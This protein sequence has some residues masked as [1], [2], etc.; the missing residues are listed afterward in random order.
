MVSAASVANLGDYRLKCLFELLCGSARQVLQNELLFGLG[1]AETLVLL[2]PFEGH[3][4]AHKRGD[5]DA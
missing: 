1:R 5:A 2:R 3:V 4:Q